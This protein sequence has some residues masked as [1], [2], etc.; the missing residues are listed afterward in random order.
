LKTHRF[1]GLFAARILTRNFA[2][3]N[4]VEAAE[5]KSQRKIGEG[6]GGPTARN[7]R[8]KQMKNQLRELLPTV[9]KEAGFEDE[10]VIECEDRR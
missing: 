6:G 2:H 1:R 5:G 10:G 4:A 7:K 3:G 9:L 8:I